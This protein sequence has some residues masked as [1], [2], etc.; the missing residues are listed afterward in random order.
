MTSP[1]TA[2]EKYLLGLNSKEIL[3]NITWDEWLAIGPPYTDGDFSS[4]DV[5]ARYSRN[6]YDWDI[7]GT[8]YTPA[9]EVNANSAFVCFHGGAGSEKIMD[10]T[11]DGRPG[12]ARVLAAQGFKVLNLTYPGH[13]PPGGVWKIPISERMPIYLMDRELSTEEINDR[14]LKCTFN[15]ILQGAALLTDQH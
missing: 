8:L 12:L 4:V 3:L 9:K 2:V 10:L 15:V 7:H 6:G 13:Y 5:T 1:E 14:N 11:P